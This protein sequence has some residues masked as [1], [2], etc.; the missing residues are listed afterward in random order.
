LKNELISILISELKITSDN[1]ETIVEKG[2][3]IP[4]HFPAFNQIKLM[5]D[6]QI[7]KK[8]LHKRNKELN[9]EVLKSLDK[10]L[11]ENYEEDNEQL[12]KAIKESLEFQRQTSIKE[13][14]E[15][16]ELDETLKLSKLEYEEYVKKLKKSEK[17]EFIA[18][19]PEKNIFKI[20]SKNLESSKFSIV[21]NFN[22]LIKRIQKLM[23]RKNLF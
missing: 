13:A 16:E 1:F 18:K 9:E 17:P 23:K 12:E 6:F 15:Q 3:S 2:L 19:H 22:L 10:N 8:M 4:L 7:F 5:E 11:N 20:R 21:S 14:K